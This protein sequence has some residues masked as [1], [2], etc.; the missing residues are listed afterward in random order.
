M[1]VTTE[2]HLL[3]EPCSWL[4]SSDDRATTGSR[5][6]GSISPALSRIISVK[7]SGTVSHFLDLQV[8][9]EVRLWGAKYSQ[10]IS[11]ERRK[12]PDSL[13]W[14]NHAQK[15]ASY[16]SLSKT[17]RRARISEKDIALQQYERRVK[18]CNNNRST[19]YGLVSIHLDQYLKHK[20]IEYALIG[21]ERY[22]IVIWMER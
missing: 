10:P 14:H 13:M 16:W 22:A 12:A 17:C 21:R 3:D 5:T 9:A 19:R 4:A 18:I 2:L 7:I 15:R 1:Q 11:T 8:M 20:A 6:T